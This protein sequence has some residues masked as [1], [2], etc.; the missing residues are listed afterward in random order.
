MRNPWGCKRWL[1]TALGAFL[2]GALAACAE[3]R[4]AATEVAPVERHAAA[5]MRSFEEGRLE[6]AQGEFDEALG[7]DAQYGPAY[8]GKGLVLGA[9]AI[10]SEETKE[11]AAVTKN[12][13]ASLKNGKKYAIGDEQKVPAYVAYIRLHTMIKDKDW[14]ADAEENFRYATAVDR[15]ASAAYFFMGEAYKEAYRF[16][17]AGGMYRRVLDLGANYTGEARRAWELTQRIQQAAPGTEA[18]KQIALVSAITRAEAAALFMQELKLNEVYAKLGSDVSDEALG[19][20]K[21]EQKTESIVKPGQGGA[22]DLATHPLGRDVEA[23]LGLG[24]RGLEL[25]PDRTFR[26]GERV[27]RVEFAVMVEGILIRATGDG[28]LATQFTG[29]PSPFVDLRDDSPYF[30][31]VMVCTSTGIMKPADLQGREFRPMESV[32]GVDALLTIRS[33]TEYLARLK[34]G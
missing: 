9:K 4:P 16:A 11:R 26:P 14:L 22:T 1:L 25:Y 7:L 17:D 15:R 33:L 3:R 29:N 5:G 27:T 21:S 18:G 23:V 12:A 30:N 19:L 31:A 20:P 32:A 2:V 8:V 6:E 28:K 24:V 13:F 34:T 10:R